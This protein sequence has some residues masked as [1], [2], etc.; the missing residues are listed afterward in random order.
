V[1]LDGNRI[2]APFSHE[3]HYQRFKGEMDNPG[4]KKEAADIVNEAMGAEFEIVAHLSTENNGPTRAQA[5]QSHLVRAAQQ[6]GAR[7]V[8]QKEDESK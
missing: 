6:M 4:V 3:S 7:I 5:N 2:V 1:A 8:D